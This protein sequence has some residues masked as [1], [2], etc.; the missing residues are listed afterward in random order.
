MN[1]T[2]THELKDRIKDKEK[3]TAIYQPEH[4]TQYEAM[5][6]WTFLMLNNVPM[7]EAS[8]CKYTLRWRKKNGIEDLKKARRVLDMLIELETNRDKYTP[9]VGCL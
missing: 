1:H 7:A 2:Q 6:P 3:G 9:E 8:V 4:Y 5:E